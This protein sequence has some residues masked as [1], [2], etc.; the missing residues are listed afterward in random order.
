MP[1][2]TP[3]TPWPTAA[4]PAGSTPTSSASVSAKPEKMP[5][6]FEPPPTHAVTTSGPRPSSRRTAR[7]A[8]SPMTRWN[9]RTIHGYGCGPMTE[10][11]Q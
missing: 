2:T 4:P 6:A 9:S 10:P 11:R 5:M 1:C 8:S 3:G 7:G